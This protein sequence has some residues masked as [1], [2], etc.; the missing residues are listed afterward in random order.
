M[1]YDFIYNFAIVSSVSVLT[2]AIASIYYPKETKELISIAVWKTTNGI[3][4]AK[5]KT[6]KTIEMVN[7]YLEQMKETKTIIDDNGKEKKIEVNKIYTFH[8]IDT[9]SKLK[10]ISLNFKECMEFKFN[11]HSIYY[12]QLHKARNEKNVYKNIILSE[13]NKINTECKMLEY[14][15][16]SQIIEKPFIHVTLNVKD[17]KKD[18]HEYLD[19]YYVDGNEIL[20]F[21]FLKWYLKHYYNTQLTEPYTIDILDD[22]IQMIKLQ[23]NQGIYIKNNTYEIYEVKQNNGTEILDTV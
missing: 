2:Y 22:K 9:M 1:F 20:T 5:R 13:F 11:N 12:V 18:I 8:E 21:K 23:Q 16:R 7:N 6:E 14:I 3:M 15:Q 17:Q 19:K 10:K 4:Y